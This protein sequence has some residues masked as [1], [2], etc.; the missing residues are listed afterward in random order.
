MSKIRLFIDASFET[1]TPLSLETAQEHYLLHVMRLKDGSPVH[2]FNGKD[3]EWVAHFKHDKRHAHLRLETQAEPQT[4]MPEV[5]L[6]FSPL[7]PKRLEFL[8]EKATELNVGHLYPTLMEHTAFPKIKTEK[9]QSYA[10]EAAEQSER[11]SIP[12]IYQPQKLPDLLRTWRNDYPILWANERSD[13]PLLFKELEKIEGSTPLTFLIGPEGGFSAHEI[14][15][16]ETL[17][18]VIPISLGST[19][20][21]AETAAITCLAMGLQLC[22]EA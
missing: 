19:I 4:T 10:I 20:L 18:F 13:C 2:V 3:G 1:G 14:Q 15:H 12:K 6:I 7:K 5:G 21:R 11:L 16:L 8:I 9:I 17:S 22:Y